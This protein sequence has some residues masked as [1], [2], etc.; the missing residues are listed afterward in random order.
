MTSLRLHRRLAHYG[1][2]AARI[3]IPGGRWQYAGA[4]VCPCCGNDT[5]FVLAK[6]HARWIRELSSAWENSPQFKSGLAIRESNLC[7]ICRA[8]FRVRAQAET[9]LRVLGL[10]RT[11]AVL[12]K[13]RAEAGFSV[14]ETATRNVLRDDDILS[15]PNYVTSEYFENAVPGEFVGGVMN[16]NLEALTFDND[17]FDVVLTSEVLE[18]VADLDRALSEIQRVLKVG[19][20]HIFTVPSDPALERTVER[21]R[22]VN[23]ELVHMR[24][25]VLHGDSMRSAGILAFRDF[26][27]DTA[28]ITSRPGFPCSESVFRNAS[29]FVTSVFVARKDS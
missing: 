29:G 13:L 28:R 15:Q 19:G 2:A 5:L 21:A 11:Q 23:G 4:G 1:Y 18:H 8:N 7:A 24:V 6:G 3:L 26:G 27:V 20:H 25:P 9:L 14:Y 17:I 16:Q 22:Y 10:D 12:D